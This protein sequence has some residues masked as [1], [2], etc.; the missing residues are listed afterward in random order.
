[1]A[2]ANQQAQLNV[3]DAKCKPT[4]RKYRSFSTL[5]SPI[6]IISTIT[7]IVTSTILLSMKTT[8]AAENATASLVRRQTSF[9]RRLR[10]YHRDNIVWILLFP[11]SAGTYTERLVDAIAQD[12]VWKVDNYAAV[13]KIDNEMFIN[14]NIVPDGGYVVAKTNCGGVCTSECP[15]LDY[16]LTPDLFLVQCVRNAKV[17][18]RSVARMTLNSM[19]QMRVIHLFR[20]PFSNV[21]ARYLYE[22]KKH[23]KNGADPRFRISIHSREGF[24]DW[25]RNMDSR[26]KESKYWSYE[27][28]PHMVKGIPCFTEFFKWAQWHN[29]AFDG[30]DGMKAKVHV[31][32]HTDYRDRLDEVVQGLLQF[33]NWVDRVLNHV[34]PFTRRTLRGFYTMEEKVKIVGFIKN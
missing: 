24:K 13:H 18:G 23:V 5:K 20:S 16:I 32:H 21:V 2:P 4:Q 29:N 17:N 8:H 26:Q 25:C 9:S 30:Y 22:M 19:A 10:A 14:E 12:T 1:M 27:D 6:S 34:P 31:V 11:H 15:P 7:I 33:L 3:L 28:K